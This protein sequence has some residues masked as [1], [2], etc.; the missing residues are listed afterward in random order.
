MHTCELLIVKEY[1]Q[2]VILYLDCC[3]SLKQNVRFVF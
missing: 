3:K 1:M 2:T